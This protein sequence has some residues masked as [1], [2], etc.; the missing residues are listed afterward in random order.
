MGWLFG[1]GSDGETFRMA[2]LLAVAASAL[3]AAIG[4]GVERFAEHEL[5]FT[6]AAP[7]TALVRPTINTIDYATTGSIRGEAG[8]ETVIL[9]PCGEH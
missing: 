3:A 2:V 5:S 8:K 9:S 1:D 6:A 4:A 7:Q